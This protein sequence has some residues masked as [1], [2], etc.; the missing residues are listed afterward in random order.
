MLNKIKKKIQDNYF[1]PSPSQTKPATPRLEKSKRPRK[2]RIKRTKSQP[3]ADSCLKVSRFLLW[4]VFFVLAPVLMILSSRSYDS[5]SSF[6]S[7]L[8]SMEQDP[9]SWGIGGCAVGKNLVRGMRSAPSGRTAL[10]IC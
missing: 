10:H 9:P 6:N 5:R 8:Y 4:S 3:E 1:C 7:C 2:P